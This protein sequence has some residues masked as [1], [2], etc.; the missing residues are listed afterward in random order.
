V[1]VCFAGDAVC[2]FATIDV[3]TV[4]AVVESLS[5]VRAEWPFRWRLPSNPFFH[6][7]LSPLFQMS[8]AIIVPP[9]GDFKRNGRAGSL[10]STTSLRRF[11]G[12]ILPF[13]LAE[14]GTISLFTENLSEVELVLVKMMDGDYGLQNII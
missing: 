12:T 3:I 11:P 1:K 14:F 6:S 13:R 7:P 4:P 2:L 5:A 8:N 9:S 10:V